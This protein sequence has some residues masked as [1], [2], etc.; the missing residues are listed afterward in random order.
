MQWTGL[1][2]IFNSAPTKQDSEEPEQRSTSLANP[3]NARYFAT[4]SFNSNI[5]VNNDTVFKIAPAWA[6]LSYI[7]DGIA[8]LGRGVFTRDPDGDV[9]P[10]FTSPV[11]QLFNGRPHPHY[12]THVFLQALTR[13]ACLGN[14]FAHIHRDPVTMRP[15]SLEII[16][17]ELVQLVYGPDGS[18][19]YW[20]SGV[21]QDRSVNYVLPETEMLHIKG[22]TVTGEYGRKVSLVHRDTFAVN[23]AAQQYSNKFFE[24][25]ASLSGIISF[26]NQLTKEQ[27]EFLKQEFAS[28]YGGAL[29]AGK[30]MPLDGGAKYE[31]IQSNPQEA[32]V[33]DFRNLSTEEVSQIFKV[34]LH[35]LSKLDNSS[36][37]NME[38]QNQDF[39]LH[40]LQ[41]WSLQIQEEFTTKLF[42]TS[43]VRN[44][45]RFFAFD[46][47]TMQMGDMEA[48]S[49]F[50]ASAIQNGWMTPNE[51]RAKKNLNKVE[52]GDQLFIQQ[53]MA[54]MDMLAEILQ[55]KNGQT[56]QQAQT[57]GENSP[58]GDA[59]T[60]NDAD[61]GATMV[62]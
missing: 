35:L 3:D 9:F 24:Q 45:R 10:D 61:N 41:P 22:V 4:P 32:A 47:S 29:N 53:N 31:R 38:Q 14:G 54:P 57:T 46:L 15:V 11:A 20:V 13:N 6:A 16:P 5:T 19:F 27:R 33:L 43:E 23:I 42:T 7:A 56:Q 1:L 44:R 51:V 50:Y 8:S 2:S 30:V 60:D 39:V 12:N 28:K 25:G 37:S 48:Q 18:L 52:G 58:S 62:E 49:K 59:T 55:G 40:C 26:P 34:P 36:F 17:Q 21:L